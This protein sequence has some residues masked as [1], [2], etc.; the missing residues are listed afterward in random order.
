MVVEARDADLTTA[1]DIMTTDI[2]SAH[3]E[4]DLENYWGDEK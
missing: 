2:V 4:D 1:K 3:L